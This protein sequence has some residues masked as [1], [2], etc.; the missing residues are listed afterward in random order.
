M[1]RSGILTDV[2]ITADE[3]NN[4]L[5]VTAPAESMDL[6]AALIE[7]LDLPVAVAQIKVFRV[8][9][10][11]ANA[12]VLILR[13]LFP[14]ATGTTQGPSLAGAEGETSLVPLRFSVDSRSNCIIATGSDGDLKI[15]EALL[16]RLDERGLEERRNEVYRL[17]NSPALDVATAVNE[18]LAVNASWSKR[19]REPSARSS[20][21]K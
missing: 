17:K 10:A 5:L 12:L 15:I 16:L 14:A 21:P 18:F 2:Q 20:D 1:L 19:P 4:T 13:S 9:N 3:R 8:T 6:L 7:Q 11:D